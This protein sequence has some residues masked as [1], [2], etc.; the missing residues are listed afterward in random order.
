LEFLL[1]LLP[2]FLIFP[3]VFVALIAVS[4]RAKRDEAEGS[5]AFSPESRKE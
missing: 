4:L 2:V 1:I 5:K 3:V